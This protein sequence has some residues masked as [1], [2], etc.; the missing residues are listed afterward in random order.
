MFEQV[1][2]TDNLWLRSCNNPSSG[3][4]VNALAEPIAGLPPMDRLKTIETFIATAEAGSF[5]AAARN[6]RQ[7]RALVSR[8]IADLEAHLGV[9][10]FSR[11]TREISITGAG[12]Q[13][14]DVC[15]RAVQSLHQGAADLT[16][17]QRE[18]RGTL[19]IVSVRS[20]GVRHLATA[21]ADFSKLNPQLR[22]EME[23]VPGM[24][25]A[26]QLSRSGFDLGIG[27]APAKGAAT[28]PRRIAEFDWVLCAGR[29]YLARCGTP[30]HISELRDHVTMINQRHTPSGVWNFRH[31]KNNERVRIEAKIAITNFWSLREAMMA[32]AGIAILPSFCI[33]DDLSAGTV[34]PLLPELSF[35]R[36]LIWSQYPHYKGVPHKVRAFADFL[37]NRFDG[38][39]TVKRGPVPEAT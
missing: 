1:C 22:I 20:F 35:E 29:D 3:V 39:L 12:R 13:Y 8:Q 10:L 37:R 18:L 17:L 27:I 28:V 24:K 2:N 19:R 33:V 16:K 6:L 21:V 36:S 38:R 11:T 30:H 25:T 26:L 4:A 32:G 15:A 5:S 34:V 14:L 23:L 7:S 31:G 9:R